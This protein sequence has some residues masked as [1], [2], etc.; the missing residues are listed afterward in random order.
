MNKIGDLFMEK[1]TLEKIE[2]LLKILVWEIAI[3]FPFVLLSLLK[4][5][6]SN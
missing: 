1:F 5:L 4:Y 3:L 6:N 2:N